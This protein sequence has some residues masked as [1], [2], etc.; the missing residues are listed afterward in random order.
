MRVIGKENVYACGDCIKG[1]LTPTA[2]MEAKVVANNIFNEINNKNLIKPNYNLIPYAIRMSLNIAVV[3][4]ETK[5]HKT[6]PNPVGKGNYFKVSN[7]NVGITRIYY[8]NGK[9]VGAITIYPTSE[10]VPYFA[11]YIKGIDIYNDFREVHPS[12]D[13]FYK[14]ILG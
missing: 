8:E 2:R 12:T 3:G 11:Q 6:I 14:M 5:E 9:V 1:G 13:A 4:K 10:I 7:K